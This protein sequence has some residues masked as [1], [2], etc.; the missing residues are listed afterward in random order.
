MVLIT[1]EYY[2]H[3]ED[4]MTTAYDNIYLSK[5]FTKEMRNR[6]NSRTQGRPYGTRGPCSVMTKQN[7][8]KMNI[9]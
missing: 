1:V 6:S 9:I 3:S 5:G 8:H 7:K 2:M 4:H